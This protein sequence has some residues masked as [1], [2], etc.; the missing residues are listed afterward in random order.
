[1]QDD[2]KTGASRLAWERP[3][4]RRLDASDA[5][6][7]DNMKADEDLNGGP[8]DGGKKGGGSTS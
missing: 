1:V 3:T 7:N 4:L 5:Q 8:H 6:F 2:L